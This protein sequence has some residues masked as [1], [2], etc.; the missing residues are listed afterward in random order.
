MQHAAKRNGNPPKH[1]KFET[2]ITWCDEYP[3]FDFTSY[4]NIN[5]SGT[6]ELMKVT[7]K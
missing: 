5:I 3:L 6:K 2:T 1:N 7:S 4:Y